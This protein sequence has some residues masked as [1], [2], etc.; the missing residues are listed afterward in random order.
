MSWW[1]NKLRDFQRLVFFEEH[2]DH[3]LVVAVVVAQ[4]LAQVAN[5]GDQ[6]RDA[7]DARL[8]SPEDTV[9]ILPD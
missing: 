8:L 4:P 2:L 3:G 1:K 9:G 7:A 5:P 6:G